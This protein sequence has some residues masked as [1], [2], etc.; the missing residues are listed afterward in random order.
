MEAEGDRGVLL[1]VHGP[2]TIRI[3]RPRDLF[4]VSQIPT[5]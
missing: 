4:P 3:G 2:S 1:A 5:W